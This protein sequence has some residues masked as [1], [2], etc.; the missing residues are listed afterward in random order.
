MVMTDYKS[1]INCPVSG[2]PDTVA[3]NH[4][5]I[6]KVVGEMKVFWINEHNLRLGKI[7]KTASWKQLLG[8]WCLETFPMI[9]LANISFRTGRQIYEGGKV[10]YGFLSNYSE[11][12]FLKQ[13]YANGFWRLYVSD[14]AMHNTKSNTGPTLKQCFRYLLNRLTAEYHINNTLSMTQWVKLTP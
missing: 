1:C 9:I 13:D 2:I 11:T 4:A 7:K 6:L 5:G 14:V 8:K 10:R 12:V 3:L